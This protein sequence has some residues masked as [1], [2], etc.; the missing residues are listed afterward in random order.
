MRTTSLV[1][2]ITVLAVMAHVALSLPLWYGAAGRTFPQLPLSGQA[3]QPANTAG[4]ILLFCLWIALLLSVGI[5]PHRRWLLAG[6]YGTWLGLIAI[7]LNRLQPWTYFYLLAGGVLFWRK[8]QPEPALRLLAAGVYVWSGLNKL[9][10]YFAEENFPWL[11]Q[12]F[13]FTKPFGQYTTL[14]YVA[15]MVEALFGLG[16]LWV[17]CRPYVRWAVL[18]FHLFI[19]LALSPLGLNWNAVVIP[20]N[21]AMAALVWICTRTPSSG[22]RDLGPKMAPRAQQRISY[23]TGSVWTILLFA[24]FLP[25]L[26]KLGLWPEALSW[27]MYANTQPEA[28]FF[29]APGAHVCPELQP[30]W[31]RHSWDEGRRLLFDDWAI[32]E[33]QVPMFN[34]PRAHRQLAQYLCRCIQPAEGGLWRMEVNPWQ[35]DGEQWQETPCN[36]LLP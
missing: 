33:L 35:T 34:H 7:D 20:W 21:F 31:S 3:H 30:A 29:K 36:R 9:T 1:A 16:L 23:L 18:V 6:A 24:W 19:V 15:A 27:K 22:Q 11:C 2:R 8:D 5:W 26:N 10:P 14:G 12:A 17:Q 32:A 28:G 25:A 13:A 4:E